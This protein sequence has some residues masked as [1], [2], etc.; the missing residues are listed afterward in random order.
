MVYS[1][2][3]YYGWIALIGAMPTVIGAYY[4]RTSFAP[5]M[6]IMLAIGIALESLAPLIAGIIYDSRGTYIPAF[7]VVAGFS[8]V[9]LICFSFSH[10]PGLPK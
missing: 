1:S 7:A 8:L 2:R 4:G 9:G 6:G 5:L 3:I 10:K